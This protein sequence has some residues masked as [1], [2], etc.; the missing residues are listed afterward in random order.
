MP[1]TPS[2]G[3]QDDGLAKQ[4]LNG[5]APKSTAPENSLNPI[6]RDT[7]NRCVARKLSRGPRLRLQYNSANVVTHTNRKAYA[8]H[9]SAPRGKPGA[10][11]P[12]THSDSHTILLDRSLR[13]PLPSPF[14]RF[15]AG[16]TFLWWQYLVTWR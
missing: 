15:R 9:C 16:S 4:W 11:S 3:I 13:S 5:E 14:S 6:H 12:P 7:S 1:K 2:N 10:N 8:I